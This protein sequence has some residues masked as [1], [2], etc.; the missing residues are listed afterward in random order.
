M[1]MLMADGRAAFHSILQTK[2]VYK[3]KFP[4]SSVQDNKNCFPF[5][6]YSNYIPNILHTT[7]IIQYKS[8]HWK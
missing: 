7:I 8:L 1:L 6:L 4:F 3:I 2:Q 5:L